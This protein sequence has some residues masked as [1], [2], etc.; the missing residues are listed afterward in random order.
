MC[1]AVSQLAAEELME[2]GTLTDCLVDS[3]G[4][5]ISNRLGDGGLLSHA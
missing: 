4:E 2:M 5:N 3:P 1:C